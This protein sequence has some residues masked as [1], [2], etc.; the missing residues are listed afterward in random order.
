MNNDYVQYG[1]GLCAPPTWLNFDASPTLR[2][3]RL[4]LLGA[5]YNK[6]AK[7][8]PRHVQYGDITR[9]LPVSSDS[10]SGI[11]CSHVLEHLA[12]EDLD[13]ALK[14][15]F[16]YVK[17]G[18]VFRLVVPDLEHMARA[19]LADGSA[20]AAVRFVENT[21]LGRKAVPRGIRGWLVAWLG[22][23]HH[24][25]MWDEKSMRERLRS[26]GFKDIR[27][28]AFGDAEDKRFE[29]VEDLERFNSALAMQCRK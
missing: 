19:Y 11:Y 8:F 26:H 6:N 18:G 5:L 16:R 2:L 29:E 10:C 1:C 28:A 3:E 17:P 13:T 21:C 14:N 27:R 4:P 9:G 25:W 15:T 23:R 12:L 22:S 20:N 7:L 24:L